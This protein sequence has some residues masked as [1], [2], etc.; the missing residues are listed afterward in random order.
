[1]AVSVFADPLLLYILCHSYIHL[2]NFVQNVQYSLVF[3]LLCKSAYIFLSIVYHNYISPTVFGDRI[4]NQLRRRL[5][6]ITL[7][8]NTVL[9]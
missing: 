8:G 4:T 6:S 3:A 1:M 7:G 5:T 9:E 2:S